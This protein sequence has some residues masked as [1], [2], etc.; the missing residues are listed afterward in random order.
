MPPLVNTEFTREKGGQDGIQ[1]AKV[2]DR[3]VESLEKGEYEIHIGLTA[4]FYK[5]HLSSPSEAFKA[6]NEMRKY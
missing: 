6:L 2:A 3:L 4:Y 5:L 1:V